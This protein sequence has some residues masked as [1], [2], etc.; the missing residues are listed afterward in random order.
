MKLTLIL[1]ILLAGCS[2]T[3]DEF[4]AAQKKCEEIG[5]TPMVVAV[6]VIEIRCCNEVDCGVIAK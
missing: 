5:R 6:L 3:V 2:P 4:K 1:L